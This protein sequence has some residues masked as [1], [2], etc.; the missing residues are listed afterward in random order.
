MTLARYGVV[1]SDAE[2]IF[3]TE[4]TSIQGARELG[5]ARVQ[6][7]G[8]NRDLRHVKAALAAKVRGMG[9]NGLVRFTYGQRGNPWYRSLSGLF[10]AEHWYGEGIVVILPPNQP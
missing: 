1:G 7:G 2:G 9:G 8:Q 3:F 6:I 10:D 5:P 4:A